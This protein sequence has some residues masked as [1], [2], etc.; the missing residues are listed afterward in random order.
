MDA[1]TK[2]MNRMRENAPVEILF[3]VDINHTV[4]FIS[5]EI[6]RLLGY[7]AYE[8]IGKNFNNYVILSDLPKAD[9]TFQAVISEEDSKLLNIRVK[10][11]DGK[12]FP[13]VIKLIPV[14]DGRSKIKGIRG[15]AR[16]MARTELLVTRPVL[17]SVA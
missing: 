13:L 5:P 1:E 16:I 14:F 8:V 2:E 7:K 4:E 11:R 6:K 17:G 12:I 3:E 15:V 10:S 9:N